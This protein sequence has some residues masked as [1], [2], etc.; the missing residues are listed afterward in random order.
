MKWFSISTF[1]WQLTDDNFV[2][3]KRD[4]YS[5]WPRV[6]KW[7][8]KS[9]IISTRN[10]ALTNNVDCVW[11]NSKK[12]EKIYLIVV[13]FGERHVH[14]SHWSDVC[15]PVVSAKFH[16]S[17]RLVVFFLVPPVQTSNYESM[18]FDLA[19]DCPQLWNSTNPNCQHPSRGRPSRVLWFLLLISVV[20]FPDSFFF[21]HR[22]LHHTRGLHVYII[23]PLF[24]NER[25]TTCVKRGRKKHFD[26]S[27]DVSVRSHLCN[28]AA[29]RLGPSHLPVESL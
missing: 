25:V 17:S 8:T 10:R 6:W 27:G 29:E 5:L 23:F 9:F 13:G 3:K 15:Q 1:L 16:N 21:L 2:E 12:R 4:Y 22:D 19:A 7:G 11:H 20:C 26:R 18:L 28:Q 24:P 14:D